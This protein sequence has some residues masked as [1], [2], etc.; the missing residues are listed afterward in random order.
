MK[1]ARKSF[2]A[3]R[4]IPLAAWI[5]TVLFHFT[6]FI[7][8]QFI[9][10]D[11]NVAVNN[12]I[13]LSVSA[14]GKSAVIEERKRETPVKPH[15]MK[16][17]TRASE[18]PARA[19]EADEAVRSRANVVTD[20]ATGAVPMPGVVDSAKPQ[21][22][23]EWEK[24]TE[25]EAISELK[26]LLK[27]HPEYRKRIARELLTAALPQSAYSPVF[28]LHLDAMIRG[29]DGKLLLVDP[30]FSRAA[31]GGNNPNYDPIHGFDRDKK[32]GMQLGVYTIIPVLL[33][34]LGIL[35]D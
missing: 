7:A 4:G 23:F 9:R 35:G 33:K 5:V 18:L 29:K 13:T 12:E 22:I 8:A 11:T 32:L 31:G 16:R 2:S 3:G 1:H 10:L 24:M 20:H 27:E 14:S 30:R 6:V 21:R 15:A 28:D 34:L 19:M 17:A 26:R 25:E